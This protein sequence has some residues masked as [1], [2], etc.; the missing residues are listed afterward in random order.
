MCIR[1]RV[2]LRTFRTV[3]IIEIPNSAG[4]HSSAFITPNTEYVVAGTRF[5]VP[6]D[7]TSGDVPISTYK[8]NF[9]GT[10]SFL[11]VDKTSGNM[12]IAFQITTPGVN[13]DLAHSGKGPSDGWFFFSCYN[14]EQANTLLEVNSSQKDKDFV[15]AINWK[16]AE[17]YMQEGKGVKQTV[18]YAHNTWDEAT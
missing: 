5:S 11:S 16:Q 15:M 8:E 18:K 14:T 12:S 7:N 17:K 2:D 6:L 4:N 13:F 10:V 3:E 9:K 1:D